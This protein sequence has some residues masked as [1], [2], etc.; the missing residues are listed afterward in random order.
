MA[1]ALT[2]ATSSSSSLLIDANMNRLD[3]SQRSTLV[4]DSSEKTT[5]H[6]TELAREVAQTHNSEEVT[7][8]IR[9]ALKRQLGE[10]RRRRVIAF[11]P[12]V[13][14][15]TLIVALVAA[16]I[17]M[18]RNSNDTR[19]S[20]DAT[21]TAVQAL[22]AQ[23]ANAQTAMAAGDSPEAQATLAQLQTQIADASTPVSTPAAGITTIRP[24]STASPAPEAVT[25]TPSRPT[26]PTEAPPQATSE[27]NRPPTSIV[28][29]VDTLVPDLPGVIPTLGDLLP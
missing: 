19:T 7:P 2:E 8:E 4:I 21:A 9:R 16:L 11:A 20:A 3:R 29:I 24:T 28:P 1:S 27:P 23:L 18:V 26:L 12:W 22:V 6:L 15:L 13:I 5:L 10:G 14:A 25:A 17:S